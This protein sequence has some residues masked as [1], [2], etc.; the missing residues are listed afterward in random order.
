MYEHYIFKSLDVYSPNQ[1]DILGPSA[2]PFYAWLT[3]TLPTPNGYG[4]ITLNYEKFLLDP[5]G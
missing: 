3:K 5:Q 4:R 1:V 2:N